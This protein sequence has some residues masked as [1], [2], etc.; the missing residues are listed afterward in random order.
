MGFGIHRNIVV[1]LLC[2][3]TVSGIGLNV[4]WYVGAPNST[5]VSTRAMITTASAV[6]SLRDWRSC[7]EVAWRYF[8]PGIGVNHKTGINRAK[9][10]WDASTSWDTGAY[11]VATIEAHRLGL[12]ESN[13]TWGFKDRM[14]M[15]LR[16]LL[17]RELGTNRGVSNWPYWA[18]YW[19]GRPYYN[20]VYLYADPSDSGRLL[21]ALDLLRKYDSIF[22]SQVEEVFQRCRAAY[23]L[24]STEVDR[25]LNYYGVLEAVG[26]TAFGYNK[27]H[28]ISAFENW[29]GPFV[30][31][32]GQILPQVDTTAEPTLHGVLELGLGGK[33]FEYTRRVYEAQKARWER[34]GK[35]SGWSE[36]CHP[37][38][39]Y[40][41]EWMIDGGGGTWVIKKHDGT[42]INIE[43][44]RTLPLM[45]TKVAFAYLAIFS[46]NSY[47]SSLFKAVSGLEHSEY[48]FGEAAFENG[49]SA[50][51]LWETNIEGFYS[52]NTNQIVLSAARYALLH[53]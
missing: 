42:P 3:I 47:T 39:E 4:F 21:Y 45:Y 25:H 41:Y 6:E 10:D 15:I 36:G 8:R 43:R 17:T 12:V 20:P 28:V 40:V 18:Y 44:S 13:G 11:I 32:E 23:D 7:A 50:I 2:V 53:A 37:E 26:F 1:L 29:N 51:V 49:E 9:L 27:S 31:L 33:F 14:N 35:L 34:T 22:R 24:L 19:D 5:S 16:H 52:Q 46:D 30:T 48:G 38:H